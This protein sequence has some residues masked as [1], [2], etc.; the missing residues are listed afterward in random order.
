LDVLGLSYDPELLSSRS[1]TPWWHATQATAS[2]PAPAPDADAPDA[3][4]SDAAVADAAPV[5]AAPAGPVP[6]PLFMSGTYYF[7]EKRG[8]VFDGKKLVLEIDTGRRELYD[9]VG[10]PRELR[11]LAA[12]QPETT[13]AG[14]ALLKAWEERCAALRAKLGIPT[15]STVDAS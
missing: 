13:E 14:L 3:G 9:L 12:A 10:D 1:L 8:V 4:V 2:T 5:I 11:S 7:G 6:E 15:D